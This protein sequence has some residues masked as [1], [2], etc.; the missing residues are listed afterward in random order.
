MNA[1]T[2]EAMLY[3]AIPDIDAASAKE[4][5]CSYASRIGAMSALSQH[6]PPC[7]HWQHPAGSE[8]QTEVASYSAPTLHSA[9]LR[10]RE[11]TMDQ[12][13]IALAA[14]CAMLAGGLVGCST[15]H[16]YKRAAHEL[17]TQSQHIWCWAPIEGAA[18]KKWVPCDTSAASDTEEAA[19]VE[20]LATSATHRPS[21]T[22]A[23]GEIETCMN[24]RGWRLYP[25]ASWMES[26][27]APQCTDDRP[28]DQCPDTLD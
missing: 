17:H 10:A 9:P 13:R 3:R 16:Q 22:P 2:N 1:A 7:D 8:H 11:P 15:A 20:S 4:G 25:M 18:S 6:R 24:A 21:L 14:L 12:T 27:R 5:P 28:P 23:M 19:C 26:E